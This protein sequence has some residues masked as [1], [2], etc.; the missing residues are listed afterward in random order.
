MID[1]DWDGGIPQFGE[2]PG[3]EVPN[4]V[5]FGGDLCGIT[6]KLDYIASLGVKTI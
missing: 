4:N 5:F 2:Y 6:E 3:A 1:P